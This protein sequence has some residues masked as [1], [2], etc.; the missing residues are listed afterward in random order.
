[1]ENGTRSSVTDDPMDY[2]LSDSDKCEI[3]QICVQDQG[4]VNQQARE[5]VGGVPMLGVM[6]M[7]ADVTMGGS[8]FKR[9]AAAAK[10]HKRLQTCLQDIKKLCL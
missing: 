3:R 8:T 4:S 7:G 9:V 6:D 10:L 1:M 2:L 5:I